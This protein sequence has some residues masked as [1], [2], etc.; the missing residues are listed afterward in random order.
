MPDEGKL[1]KADDEPTVKKEAVVST[2]QLESATYSFKVK[3]HAK[4]NKA[5]LEAMN[6]RFAEINDELD[7]LDGDD[8]IDAKE[9]AMDLLFQMQEAI[10]LIEMV[11]SLVS[12]ILRDIPEILEDEYAINNHY[13]MGPPVDISV[14]IEAED[15][16]EHEVAE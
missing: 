14:E 15:D 11:K 1:P 3:V 4:I 9:E 13:E 7:N 2:D 12:G 6:D 16:V 10:E 8:A 5:S